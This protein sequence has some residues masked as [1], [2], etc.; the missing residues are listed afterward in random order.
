MKISILLFPILLG[1]SLGTR[2][3]AETLFPLI[4]GAPE[5][6]AIKTTQDRKIA[7]EA[8]VYT[9][10]RGSKISLI[11]PQGFTDS[12]TFPGFQQ[13]SSGASIV[14]TEVPG[15]YSKVTAG[16]TAAT[17][18]T[19]NIKLISK[20]NI[21]I[22]G[23]KGLLLQVNQSANSIL[24]SKWITVF[25]DEQ[26]TVLVVATFPKDTAASLSRSLKDTVMSAK[27]FRNKVVDPFADL[28]FAVTDTPDLKFAKR[29]LNGLFYSKGGTFPIKSITDP[30][31]VVSEAISKVIVT[32]RKQF[33]E[34]RIS[35]IQQ[36]KNLVIATSK[37]ISIDGLSGY[38]I[39]ANASDVANNL[40][41]TVYQVMLFEAQT[42]YIIQ[43]LVGNNSQAKYLPEFQKIATSF[44]KK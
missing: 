44:R 28:K 18:K 30:L 26:E 3:N 32:D 21:T 27:W 40:P 6:T 38:E 42:Y 2:T 20:E 13:E 16:F 33:A 37:P 19:R 39:I 14:V 1:L 9:A 4:P 23:Y 8:K 17:L 36:V 24:F 34:Q 29:I 25:G 15:P 5:I 43:G 12:A 10:V 35:Q 11:K 22:N 7:P 31:L 41:T